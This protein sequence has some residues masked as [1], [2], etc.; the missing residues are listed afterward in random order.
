MIPAISVALLAC[1]MLEGDGRFSI[2]GA[3]FF[4]LA[5]GY[6]TLLYLGGATIVSVINDWWHGNFGILPVNPD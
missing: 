2:A 3:I 6:F 5:I 1:A 4:A